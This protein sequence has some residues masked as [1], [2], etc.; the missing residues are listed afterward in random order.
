MFATVFEAL[1]AYKTELRRYKEWNDKIA[2]RSQQHKGVHM[3]SE[4]SHWPYRLEGMQQALGLTPDKIRQIDAQVGF[5][6][7]EA[8]TT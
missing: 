3:A 1:H 4:Y 5:V 8:V 7:N 6:R 2:E